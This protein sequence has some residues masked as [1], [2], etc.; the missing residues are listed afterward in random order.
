MKLYEIDINS[1]WWVAAVDEFEAM[2]IMRDELRMR[3]IGDEEMDEVLEDLIISELSQEEAEMISVLD[4]TGDSMESL[5][6]KFSAALEPSLITSDYHKEE[7]E[8]D[9][10]YDPF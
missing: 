4:D 7:E 5:W 3:E 2:E 10:Y 6:T 1:L 8:Y 9:E